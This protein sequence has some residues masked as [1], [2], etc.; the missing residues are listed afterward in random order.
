MLDENNPHSSES[1]HFCIVLDIECLRN[2]LW[3]DMSD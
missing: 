1:E 3:L 2:I